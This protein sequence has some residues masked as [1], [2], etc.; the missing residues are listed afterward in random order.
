MNRDI[1]INKVSKSTIAD[2]CSEYCVNERNEVYFM[3]YKT[4]PTKPMSIFWPDMKWLRKT[5]G[6]DRLTGKSS[7]D[8]KITK[9]SL[10][11]SRTQNIDKM[12]LAIKLNVHDRDMKYWNGENFGDKDNNNYGKPDPETG[13]LDLRKKVLRTPAP[14]SNSYKEIMKEDINKGLYIICEYV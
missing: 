12:K 5:F 6:V 4:D 7:E 8:S 3:A 9:E 14:L 2:I 10:N 1:K 13:L 11:F